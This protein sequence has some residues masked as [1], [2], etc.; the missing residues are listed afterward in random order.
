MCWSRRSAKRD[1]SGFFLRQAQEKLKQQGDWANDIDTKATVLVGFA[2]VILGMAVPASLVNR[3]L[4]AAMILSLIAAV[5]CGLLACR[6]LTY[7]VPPNVK[8]LWEKYH[9]HDES[10]V[11]RQLTSN[12]VEA[13][14]A[15]RPR[16]ANKAKWSRAS[17]YALFAGVVFFA[18]DRFLSLPK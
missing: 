14:E 11:K 17:L 7:D 6:P 5:L 12:V 1:S 2:G 18:L 15:N 16:L 10:Q 4:A 13:V 8:S 9:D 3:C